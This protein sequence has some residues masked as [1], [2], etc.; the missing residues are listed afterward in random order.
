MSNNKGGWK[1]AFKKAEVKF[2]GAK[3]TAIIEGSV[4]ETAGPEKG[5]YTFKLAGKIV[6]SQLVGSVDTWRDGKAT[7]SGTDF[8]GGFHATRQPPE[9]EK[10]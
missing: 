7:K 1:G 10:P 3:F 8:M 2:E 6:G 9:E 5:G 4:D